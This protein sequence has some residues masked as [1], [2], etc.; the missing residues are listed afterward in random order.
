MDEDSSL[1]S[2]R[3]QWQQ[4]L[5]TSGTRRE[6]SVDV[7]QLQRRLDNVQLDKEEKSREQEARNLFER[8]SS[9]E[10]SG[11]VF[12]AIP[13]YKK[14]VNLVPD[15]EYK[16]FEWKKA[17]GE[18]RDAENNNR[19]G[20]EIET[21]K[22]TI[23]DEDDLDGVDLYSRFLDSVQ[24]GRLCSQQNV[25]S[26]THVSDLPIELF[27]IITKYVVSND[28]DTTSLERC[29]LICK[30]FYLYARDPELWRLICLKVWGVHLGSLSASSFTTW[31]Q[32]FFERSRLRF[33]GC[34]I[35]KTEYY[36][37]GENSFQDQSYKPVHHV[38]YFRYLRFFPEG[39]CL[40]MTTADEP[41]IGVKKLN[42]RQPTKTGIMRGFYRLNQDVVTILLHRKMC[43]E[44]PVIS[45]KRIKAP[46]PPPMDCEQ[47]FHIELQVKSA[48]TK[49]RFNQL[50]WQQYRVIQ[51]RNGVESSSD[52]HL[53]PAKYPVFYFS[54]VEHFSRETNSILTL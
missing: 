32:M 15:I 43:V 9:L 5:A 33:N 36:R 19:R 12:D 24:G 14:A 4:E 47:T 46:P 34:F 50:H 10:R 26:S 30:G 52:F 17:E 54:R 8:A 45:D 42:S 18:A 49:R 40:M 23:A 38:E 21:P 28:L 20:K 48:S 25:T 16:I 51:R 29:A 35:S 7:D 13:L 31:R 22:D 39:V 37:L 44:V 3:Q 1:I 11:K 53:T 27:H 41:Q 6:S 2:F